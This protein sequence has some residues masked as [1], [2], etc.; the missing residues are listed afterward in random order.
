[1]EYKQYD[2]RIDDDLCVG[3]GECIDFCPTRAINYDL[4]GRAFFEQSLCGA[5]GACTEVDC[6]TGAL[7]VS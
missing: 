2:V 7:E 6:P 1:M 3:C 4:N 5:C